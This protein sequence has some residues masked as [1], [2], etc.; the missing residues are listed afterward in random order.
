[1]EKA[2]QGRQKYLKESIFRPLQGSVNTT[3]YPQGS[4]PGLEICRPLRGCVERLNEV[5]QQSQFFAPTAPS[6]VEHP[7]Y[8]RDFLARLMPTVW[9]NAP[10][11][12]R[13]CYRSAASSSARPAGA[14]TKK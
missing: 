4:R 5:L 14:A 9:V 13:F 1:M 8:R 6:H 12:R 3:P 2:L 7:V 11:R 10:P